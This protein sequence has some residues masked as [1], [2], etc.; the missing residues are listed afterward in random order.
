MF[1]N[2][3]KIDFNF[4]YFNDQNSLLFLFS[5]SQIGFSCETNFVHFRW[6]ATKT[7]HFFLYI[8]IINNWMCVARCVIIEMNTSLKWSNYKVMSAKLL[9]VIKKLDGYISREMIWNFCLFRVSSRKKNT[10]CENLDGKIKDGKC[11][12]RPNCV[13]FAMVTKN[14]TMVE[15]SLSLLFTSQFL[16]VSNVRMFFE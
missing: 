14:K 9:T 8:H 3:K 2:D 7:A 16:I 13:P 6:I 5:F 15:G 10:V 11:E 1:L 4:R 12:N